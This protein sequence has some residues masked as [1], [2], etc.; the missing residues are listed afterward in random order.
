MYNIKINRAR[1]ISQWGKY[2]DTFRNIINA[3]P[4]EI[5]KALTGK[6]LAKLI[7][8]NQ[9]IYFAGQKKAEAEIKE[10]LDVGFW[11]IDWSD[12]LIKSLPMK[13]GE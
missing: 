9:K 11:D 4:E 10:F 3:I 1:K 6:Q 8:A 2:P 5:I 13:K 12:D 7:E